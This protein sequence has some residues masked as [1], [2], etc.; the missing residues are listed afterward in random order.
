MVL[1]PIVVTEDWYD[2]PKEFHEAVITIRFK[3]TPL[4]KSTENE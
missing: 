3:K 1:H 4:D 2:N